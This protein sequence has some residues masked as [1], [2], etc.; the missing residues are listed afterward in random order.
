MRMHRQFGDW[1][2]VLL[3]ALVGLTACIYDA[4]VRQL[5]PA[6]QAEF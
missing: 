1:A 4:A 3:V 6:E 5:S 2:A